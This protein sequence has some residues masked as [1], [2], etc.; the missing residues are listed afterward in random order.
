M[1]GI[2]GIYHPTHAA[3]EGVLEKAITSLAHRGPDGEGVW[4]STQKN[5]GMAHRRLNIVDAL[6]GTQPMQNTS[7]TICIVV[8]GEIYDDAALR[9]NLQSKGYTPQTQ[10]DSEL[11]IYLYEEYGLDFVHHLRGEFAFILYDK[12][13]NRMIAVRDRFGIKPLCYYYTP[14]G[15]LYV[16]SEAKAIF[17]MGVVP[18]WNEYALYQSL[19]FQYPPLNQTLFKD[20]Q[21]LPP[22]HMMIYDGEKRVINQYWDLDYQELNCAEPIENLSNQLEK[23][24]KNAIACRLRSDEAKLCCHLS[25]GI[26]SATIAYLASELNGKPLP[27]FSVSFPHE[28]YDE[29]NIAQRF[30]QSIEAPFHP[31]LVGVEDMLDVLSDALYYSEG[32]AINNHLSAKYILNR[33]IKQAG[34]TIALSGEGS[35]EL[36]AGYLHLQHDYQ[37]PNI[38]T[39]SRSTIASGIHVS[40]DTTLPLHMIQQQLG[41]IPAFIKAKAAVGH[42]LHQLLDHRPLTS[43]QIFRDIL[44]ADWLSRIA[45]LHP[46]HQSSYLWIKY[47]LSGYILKTL[48]DGCEMAHGIEGRVPFLDHHLFAFSK[49]IPLSLKLKPNRDKFILRETVKHWLTPEIVNRQK[50]PFM[51]PPFS[52]LR[53]TKGIEFVNDCLR[54]NASLPFFNRIKVGQY[55][56]NLPRQSIRHQIAAEP[57]IML[58]LTSTLLGQ[59]Y[60][61]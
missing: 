27:C 28:R 52:L 1:C 29:V 30:A 19:C 16:A 51:A 24:L 49:K 43:E 48:G 39:K 59:R 32:L 56:D 26:D 21:L 22:G 57:V 9:K 15:T 7:K 54:S 61:L 47:A 38:T 40:N 12:A 4:Y 46:V 37:N 55:L 41:F 11:I 36:F 5:V 20:V 33:A 13:N 14:D 25:G 17:A 58:M 34:Y 44:P 50:H 10:S 3:Q 6:N 23:Q 60:N 18:A 8:N 45:H 2:L 35:D 53:N 31:V 42:K